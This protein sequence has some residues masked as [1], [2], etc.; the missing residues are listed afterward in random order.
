MKRFR[1]DMVTELLAASEDEAIEFLESAY[2]DVDPEPA[3]VMVL[4]VKSGHEVEVPE[5]VRK[6]ASR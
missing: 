5:W 1:V 2:G 6:A 3:R 4:E